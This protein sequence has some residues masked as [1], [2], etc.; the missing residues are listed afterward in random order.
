MKIYQNIILSNT[1]KILLVLSFIISL[2]FQ[3]STYAQLNERVLHDSDLGL[4]AETD[5]IIASTSI[6]KIIELD[7]YY[8][9]Q[10][11]KHLNTGDP[12]D[13]SGI[14][15]DSETT[16]PIE[17]ALIVVEGTTFSATTGSNGEY[18]IV[19]IP[20]GKY[21]ITATAAGYNSET[22]FDQDVISGENTIID[23]SLLIIPGI[24][25]GT[26]TDS[27]TL[28]PIE[29]AIIKLEGT[30]YI[31]TTG[32]D[33]TY[34]I[35]NI[36]P[37]IYDITASANNYYPETK[38]NQEVISDEATV[39]DFSLFIIPGIISGTITDSETLIHIE[40]A[41]V[42]IEGT[43]H[44]ATTVEDG[45]Y[46]IN[47]IYPGIYN[48]TATA[49]NYYQETKTNQEVIS[50][51]ATVIDFSLLIIP[52]IISGTITDSETLKPI[53][54]AIVTVGGTSH[55]A[56][57]GENG[58]YLITD[59]Y[60]GIYEITA[61]S[62]NY[63]P[64]TKTNQEVISGEITVIDFSLVRIPGI[65]SGTIIDS[66]SLTPI[67][68]AIIR[69]IGTEYNATTGEDG[70]YLITDIY[71]GI[72]EVNARA[73][74][75]FPETKLDMEV[76]SGE[77]NVID[78]SLNRIPGIISGIVLDSRNSNPIVGAIVT[79]EGT[80]YTATSGEDGNYLITDIYPGIYEITA[81]S[82]NYYPETKTNQEVISGETSI[83]D[84]A[85]E[86]LP[87][88]ISG[89]I[90]N[91][92]FLYPIEGAIITIEGT[93]HSTQSATDGTFL[94]EN[95]VPGIYD[96]TATADTYYP[97]TISGRVVIS[98]Q[99]TI[100]NFSLDKIPTG[101][102]S[103]TVI[104]SETLNPLENVEITVEGTQYSTS[105][106][107]NGNYLIENIAIG[108]YSIIAN[109]NGYYTKIAPYKEVISDQ[110]TIV[111]FNLFKIPPGSVA[112]TIVESGTGNPIDG[113]II[114][115]LGTSYSA[116]SNETGEYLIEDVGMGIYSIAVSA[117]AYY[118]DTIHNQEVFEGEI[119]FVDFSLLQKFPTGSIAGT[120]IDLITFN[121]IEGAIV[122]IEETSQTAISGANGMYSIE[123]VEIG[124]YSITADANGYYP[125]TKVDQQIFEGETT[126]VNFLLEE[127]PTGAISGTINDINTGNP[128]EGAE[129]TVEKEGIIYYFSTSGYDGTFTINNVETG[130]YNVTADAK[131]YYSETKP[132]QV[133]ISDETTI[134]DF[135]LALIPTGTIMGNVYDLETFSGIEGAEIN[136]EGTE[137]STI[138]D[139]FGAYTIPEIEIGTYDITA[140]AAGFISET[141]ANQ[142]VIEGETTT[143]DF[144]LV[145]IPTG[146]ITGIVIDSETLAGIEGAEITVVG[147]IYSAISGMNGIY[148][149]EDVNIGEYS[150][151]AIALGYFPNILHNQRVRQD[152]TITIDFSLVPTPT[153]GSISGIITD[154]I[155]KSP[156]EGAIISVEGTLYNAISNYAGEYTITEVIPG[157]Y[158]ITSIANGYI[159]KTIS[160]TIIISGEVTIADFELTQIPGTISGTV[161]DILTSNP[162]EGAVI[163]A[164][165]NS[166]YQ[167]ISGEGGIYLLS[168]INPGI[169]DLIASADGYFPKTETNIE[170]S[171]N[172]ITLVDFEL[173]PISGSITGKITDYESMEAIEGAEIIAIGNST[174]YSTNS[175]P[176]GIYLI[177]NIEP[178]FYDV[179]ASAIGYTSETKTNQEVFIDEITFVDFSLFSV[180]LLIADF[181]YDTVCEGGE[182][183]FIDQSK[184][185]GINISKWK[186]DFGDGINLEYLQYKENVFHN[187]FNGGKFM[188][189]LIIFSTYST[190][191]ISDTIKKYVKVKQKPIARFISDSVCR[192]NQTSF[193]DQSYSF[194]DSI[195]SWKWDFG[196]GSTSA[197]QDPTYKYGSSGI[198]DVQLIVESD[199][200]CIDTISNQVFVY[201]LPQSSFRNIVPCVN[202]GTQF[203]DITITDSVS[204]TEWSW[205]FGDTLSSSD[206]SS[207]QNPSYVYKLVGAYDVSLKV[208]DSFGCIDNSKKI[209]TVY[210]IP[211][212]SFSIET[213]YQ[214]ISGQVKFNNESAL[215]EEYFWDFGNGET[216]TEFDPVIKYIDDF[217]YFISLIAYNEY[218]CTDTSYLDY[219]FY[220][221]KLFIPNA[222]APE[223][224]NPDVRVFKPKGINI[225]AYLLEIYDYNGVLLWYSSELDSEG[226][227][228]EGWDGY[229]KGK[230][231]PQGVYYWR[232]TAVF[233]DETKWVGSDNG[234]DEGKNHGTFMLIR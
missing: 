78:F 119:T 129:L 171:F 160:D 149:I 147:T 158:N 219:E 93:T 210:P 30:T 122:T 94:I 174:E 123:E 140:N 157:I 155:T 216:S 9:L 166:T 231:M 206:V 43:S 169:Y 230:L 36:Y 37:G 14:V 233:D 125:D 18:F 138:T 208:T 224:Q 132:D 117:N 181:T 16:D 152:E 173:I 92:E 175:S 136:V 106:N 186:W 83:I 27:E 50:G 29:G 115:I 162:I 154:S 204:I 198:Y 222:F 228:A 223:D 28:N 3:N 67:E 195:I 66:E 58:N 128:I 203:E 214:E 110:T 163:F 151:S 98:E 45:S 179:T 109:A 12:G 25:S 215:A 192:G 144:S 52:G 65:I 150:V 11:L 24:I 134:V 72:Y 60:P 61:T 86:P 42:T 95:I 197:V 82:E 232:I 176:D 8:I 156:I 104:D 120:I 71:P 139:S 103:G 81:S 101:T 182:T 143:I 70:T 53:E 68:G 133:V 59:I 10:S 48:V 229:Y 88:T 2:A 201:S 111:D 188:V 113:A 207:E 46:L 189:S 213:N 146:N 194:T 178:G 100:V 193:N 107:S 142:E 90:I 127:T 168:D 105:T 226:M 32:E 73:N 22:K 5:K 212:S 74:E 126:T 159:P 165:G 102:I 220:I 183:K 15:S 57:T 170:V 185:H 7:E 135:S 202:Q 26:I 141:K 217:T 34:S 49:N 180:P 56:S 35:T 172:E 218:N 87:G 84:F 4:L 190:L 164:V 145:A 55:T 89:T 148:S 79:L 47:N 209:I 17:G 54:G 62:D 130:I 225:S 184:E 80:I 31:A 199:K 211:L 196:N 85:L 227:P 205:N 234:V 187:Y 116:I 64:E 39:I 131:G 51:E 221:K 75:Y 40:G 124:S 41:I 63:F 33:G 76:I 114:S 108:T 167:G 44:T 191:E 153:T 13:I 118:P 6:I 121:P 161:T 77:T 112:G 20:A 21:D 19:G 69:L 96:L 38:A 99:I 137:Y 91:S 1:N 177:N 23:F 97:K 200:S